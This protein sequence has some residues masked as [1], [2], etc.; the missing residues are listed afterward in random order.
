MVGSDAF[1]RS[2]PADRNLRQSAIREGIG[3]LQYVPD[4][5]EANPI[6][7]RER[8]DVALRDN[9]LTAE[10]AEIGCRQ[11]PCTASGPADDP[12]GGDGKTLA[13]DNAA[14]AYD[15]TL[16]RTAEGTWRWI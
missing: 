12:R 1:G 7:A 4:A 11:G 8:R 10:Q 3:K 14:S 16:K 15:A 13:T 9:G 5:G 2:R 6:R